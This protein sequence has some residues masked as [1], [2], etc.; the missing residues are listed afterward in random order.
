MDIYRPRLEKLGTDRET[1]HQR[2]QQLEARLEHHINEEKHLA[3]EYH[4]R[5][6]DELRAER[7]SLQE[8]LARFR[9][10]LNQMSATQH[11]NT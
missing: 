10:K 4:Q 3:A 5:T 11:S 7:L 6:I 1:E 8:Q 9:Q 2:R